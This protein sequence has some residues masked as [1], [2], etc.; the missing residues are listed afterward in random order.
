MKKFIFNVFSLLLTIL[1]FIWFYLIGLSIHIYTCYI[2]YESYGLF[3]GVISFFCPYINVIIIFI[4][5]LI[6][7]GLFNPYCL[8]ILFYLLGYAV[9][10]GLSHLLDK[11]EAK[12]TN[13]SL[14]HLDSNKNINIPINTNESIDNDNYKKLANIIVNG[15]NAHSLD[16]ALSNTYEFYK[17]Q[18]INVDTI[19]LDLC[20]KEKTLSLLVMLGLGT[21]SIE[22]AIVKTREFYNI[23]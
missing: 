22:E 7:C 8:L 2:I 14:N 20:N 12:C 5:Y 6:F 15:L 23:T 3:L 16:E 17:E 10:I 1:Y 18:G 21:N 9:L 13:H 11:F 4:L 19:K